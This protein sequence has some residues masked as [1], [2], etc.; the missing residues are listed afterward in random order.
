MLGSGNSEQKR[1]ET[2][3]GLAGRPAKSLVVGID[4]ED[5]SSTYTV[6]SWDAQEISVH[7]SQPWSVQ[8][9]YYIKWSVSGSGGKMMIADD[10]VA[11]KEIKKL[12]LTTLTGELR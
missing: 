12:S 1:V 2:L 6:R 8:A 7:H 5:R 10:L 9:G 4:L 11:A 3:S